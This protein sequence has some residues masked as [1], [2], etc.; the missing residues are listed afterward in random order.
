[1]K[2]GDVVEMKSGGPDM[3]VKWVFNGTPTEISITHEKVP[4]VIC[5]WF[6]ENNTDLY[7][8]EFSEDQLQLLDESESEDE[9]DRDES[10]SEGGDLSG[11]G[12]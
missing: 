7:T 6:D 2:P 9:D 10:S 8:G 3:T 1:M 5:S 4:L 12:R 11:F